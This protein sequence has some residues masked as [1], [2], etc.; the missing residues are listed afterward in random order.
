MPE[1]YHASCRMLDLAPDAVLM[2]AA[3]NADLDAA[4]A[5]GLRTAFVPRPTERDD[6]AAP[7]VDLAVDDFLDLAEQLGC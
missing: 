7:D 3:H 2:V 4:R 5:C 6:H 1:A